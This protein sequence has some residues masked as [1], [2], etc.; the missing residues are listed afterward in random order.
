MNQ[1]P[2]SKFKRTLENLLGKDKF[3]TKEEDLLSYS[4]DSSY[5]IRLPSCV[6]LPEKKEEVVE[7]LR[8][9]QKYK[10]PVISRGA[11]TA[12]TGSP[13]PHKGGVVICFSKMNRIL[14]FNEEERIV[15]V[16]PG[17][18]NGELK[19]FLKKYG[20]FY[21]PDPASYAFSTIGGNVATGAG[22][23]KGLK[24]GTTKDYVLALEVVL[25][26]GKVLKTG[27]STLKCAVPYNLTPLFIGSEGTLGVF[28][29]I[30]LKVIPLPSKR[31][32]FVSIHE[33][34]EEPLD[35]ISEL[36]KK[37]ITPACAEF[38]DKTT[39][40]A[41]IKG[42]ILN[43]FQNKNFSSLLFL[44]LDGEKETLNK[45]MI[46]VEN[47]YKELKIFFEKAEDEKIIENLWEIRRSIS[48]SLKILGKKRFAEDVVVPRRFMKEL[49]F[50]I[51]NIE[52]EEG[53]YI[54]CFG[55]AGDGNFHV[56]ILFDP[57]NEKK[58]LKTREKILK[59]VLKLSGTISGE[60]GVGYIKRDFVNLELSPLQIEIM[61]KLKK[62][63]DPDGILNPQV[64]IPD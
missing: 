34:E 33:R 58:A 44:E 26:G 13:L 11:G 9:A 1:T 53:L 46:L 45:E 5:L 60:H 14:E 3:L 48:P 35:I 42:N 40:L 16:E 20:F 43:L 10:V 50:R 12:T 30:V 6:A 32:L 41:L 19:N 27:P 24:Y 47:F 31:V 52:K 25:P 63:F 8:L 29:E 7:I 38:V 59:E 15:R 21:P 36:L 23:P 51:R 64:K 18:L 17:V 4:Y 37:R 39:L 28:T 54:S 57:E 49:L 22:G 55:H 56:N 62:V 61:K 2:L